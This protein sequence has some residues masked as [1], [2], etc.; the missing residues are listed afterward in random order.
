M[1]KRTA[2]VTGASGFIGRG[3]V[4]ELKG[5]DFDVLSI[6]K[7]SG[8]IVG[9]DEIACDVSNMDRLPHLIEH[10]G[11]NH[12]FH[13]GWSGAS[14]DARN[15]I[16]KQLESVMSSV[17]YAHIAKELGCRRFIFV[18]SIAELTAKNGKT[19]I[20]GISKTFASD[21]ISEIC[22]RLEMDFI[23]V[24]IPSTYGDGIRS[25]FTFDITC[26][27]LENKDI[28]LNNRNNL[29]DLTHISDVINGMILAAERGK[30]FKTYYL[31]A[32]SPM[33]IGEYVNILSDLTSSDSKVSDKNEII[34]SLTME[35][36]DISDLKN[37][38]GYVPKIDFK[39]GASSFVEYVRSVLP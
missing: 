9:S 23:K 19:D 27:L 26:A 16:N 17:K 7:G 35:D 4:K 14:G 29:N 8:G 21:I 22:R 10:R 36:M 11:Y 1:K 31:G 13:L 37:D 18:G 34:S 39:S 2:I 25:G 6:T 5:S 24:M 30:P 3:L 28:V 32:G 38:A 12:F 33:T 15:D 20:Y